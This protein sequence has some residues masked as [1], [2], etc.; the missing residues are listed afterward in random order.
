[1]QFRPEKNKSFLPEKEI[2]HLQIISYDLV[3]NEAKMTKH[4]CVILILITDIVLYWAENLELL[5]T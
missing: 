4:K 5:I 2:D 1:M 3:K